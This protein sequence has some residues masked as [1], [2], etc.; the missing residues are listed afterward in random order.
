MDDLSRYKELKATILYHNDR[1]YNQD[2]PEITDYEYDMMMQEL[3]G[4]EQ[5][6]P[7]YIT[8][9]SPTQK[10]GGSAKREAGVLVRHNVPMLS[11]Q[12]VFSKEDVD[13]FV[14][15]MQE[16][17]VDPTFVVEYKIDGLSMA[18]RY[19]NGK[20]DVAVTRGDGVLQ[21]EDVTVNAKVIKDVKNTLKE[22]I[23]Y[24]EVRGEVYMTNEAF[25]K[26][27]EIQ[28]IKGKKLFANPRNCAAGTLRQLDSSITK[29]RNL[30]MFVFNIQD[31]KGREFTSHSE[32]YEYLKRQGIKIIE[33]YKICKTAK[34]VWEAIE[35]IGENRDKLGYDIDGAVV[36]IDSFADRQKLGATA[37]VPRWAVAYKYPPEE[38]ET[39]LL[40][41]ELSVGRTGRITPTAIFEP[42]RLC[43]TTVSRAT[44]HNQD[45]IDDLDVRIGDTIVVYKSGEIIPKVK[46]VV[47][48]KRPADSAPYVIGNTCPVCGAPA[49][50]EGDNADIKCTNHSCPSK[51][52]RNIVNFVGRDAMD[53]KGFGFAYVETLVDHGY[54]KDLSDI[55]GLIDKRQELLDKKIIGLVKST[56]NL[57]NAIEG[58]KNNDAIKLLT[59]LGI[60]N[61]G[62]SAA[63]SLMKKFKSIDNLMKA[64]YA[65]L[66]EVNDIGDISAMAIINYFKN[67][68]NQAVVQRLKEYG[69]NMNIIEAQDGDERFDGKT[70]VVT[71][72]LPTLSRKAASELIEKHGGKVSGSVSKK[73]DYL[74]AGEN[75][76]SKL[77]KAQNLGINV[78]SEETLL[79]MVK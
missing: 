16:Q 71:G 69:V 50:R 7:E 51:L 18:L 34:E 45:F 30:S 20:L 41:I 36:K 37:K 74:L 2:N 28:E 39:K 67:P 19:V 12:D 64:S 75:A 23:E 66:I 56:D 43:G 59:S 49:V 57:L 26:V 5:K 21:G 60:S 72:T 24:L 3:K 47:K 48:E 6:H 25:D 70:F 27:N 29:E 63:K 44:L 35:A 4:L 15:D 61:V 55:Y 42:I 10:V 8:S 73:T 1:Y 17:L 11:L 58:S 33:D 77:T 78:I 31:A 38:K 13:A 76:G 40:A 79:E 68:D 52:V 32:G 54:L 14:A 46:G 53:I 9:D 22:P 62:K 65:Q